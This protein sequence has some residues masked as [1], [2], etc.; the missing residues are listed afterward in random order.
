MRNIHWAYIYKVI[1]IQK[2]FSKI[3]KLN[4]NKPEQCDVVL[5]NVWN[6]TE[7]YLNNILF[8]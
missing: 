5:T 8:T 1:E 2:K 6:L 4:I 3:K 7:Q